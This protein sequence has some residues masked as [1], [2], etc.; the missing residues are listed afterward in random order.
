MSHEI[1]SSLASEQVERNETARLD[2]KT[3]IE[4]LTPDEIDFWWPIYNEQFEEL[5]RENPCR[6]SFNR[7]EFEKA[8]VSPTMAKLAYVE[9]GEIVSMCLLSNDLDHFPWLSQEFY[10]DKYP[11]FFENDNIHYFVS[12]LT[13]QDKRNQ[14]YAR[15]VLELVTELY[16]LDDQNVIITFDCCAENAQWMPDMIAAIPDSM[17][18]GSLGFEEVGT[19]HYFAGKLKLN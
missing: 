19:Q 4:T 2:G 15:E 6:Q 3:V 16:R 8:M 18:Q 1:H 12:L 11:D 13:R 10:K 7:D 9:G 14:S 5:N 17:G